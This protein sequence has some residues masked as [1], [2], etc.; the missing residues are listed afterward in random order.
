MGR[1]DII[2]SYYYDYQQLYMSVRTSE[3]LL[4]SLKLEH[5]E[6][7]LKSDTKSIETKQIMNKIETSKKI[8][9]IKKELLEQ[10]KKAIETFPEHL[11]RK[12]FEVWELSVI[13]NYTIEQVAEALFI[14]P[15]YVKEIKGRYKD[16]FFKYKRLIDKGL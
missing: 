4:E 9:G 1:K 15:A 16:K 6:L 13:K 3:I 5:D 14:V 12:E 8:L 10:M 11:K 7:F 2:Q